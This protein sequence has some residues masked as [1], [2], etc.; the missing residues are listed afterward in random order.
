MLNFEYYG[1]SAF[2]LDDGKCK[3]LF[4]P[5]LTGNPLASK[6]A[7]KVEADYVLVTHAHG[8]HIGDAPLP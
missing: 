8:D 7:D 5:F 6:K 4:D 2:L 1:H 3:L